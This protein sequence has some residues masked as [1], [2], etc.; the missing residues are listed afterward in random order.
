ME[1]NQ[2]Q[3][4]TPNGTPQ[5]QTVFD[6]GRGFGIASLV[7]A[8]CTLGLFAVIFGIIGLR[9]S[10]RAGHKNGMAVARGNV[11]NMTC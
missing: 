8:L 11:C 9:K 1:P 7:L 10:R 2:P 5:P 3:Q 4:V 6:P